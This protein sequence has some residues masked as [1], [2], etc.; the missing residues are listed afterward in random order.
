MQDSYVVD[1]TTIVSCKKEFNQKE[2]VL[3]QNKVQKTTLHAKFDIRIFTCIK[4]VSILFDR[5]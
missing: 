4:T 2:K 1:D 3:E 5:Q